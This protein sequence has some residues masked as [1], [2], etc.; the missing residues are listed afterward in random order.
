MKLKKKE[1]HNVDISSLLSKGIK[2][3]MGRYTETKF[4]KQIEGKAI[5]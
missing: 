3:L 5:H 2:I 4:G 1:D